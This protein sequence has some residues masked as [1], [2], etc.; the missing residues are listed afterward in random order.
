MTIETI[1]DTIQ[2]ASKLSET[3]WNNYINWSDF[4]TLIIILLVSVIFYY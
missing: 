4:K 3:I 1:Q 2:N